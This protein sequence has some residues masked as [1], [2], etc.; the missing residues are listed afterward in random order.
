MSASQSQ[1]TRHRPAWA[2]LWLVALL[3]FG[4]QLDCCISPYAVVPGMTAA[5]VVVPDDDDDDDSGESH[6]HQTPGSTTNGH[7]LHAWIRSLGGMTVD[8][9]RS[10]VRIPIL[11]AMVWPGPYTGPRRRP[12]DLQPR[13][14]G[15]ALLTRLGV[16]LT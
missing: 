13:A 10:L 8:L 16:S 11:R 9:V 1:P 7:R 2:V 14:A 15:V 4:F 12:E 3:L 6:A 5:R